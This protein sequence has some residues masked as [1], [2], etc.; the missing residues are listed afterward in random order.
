[1]PA[2]DPWLSRQNEALKLRGHG[3]AL[4]V[5]GRRVRLRATLPPKPTDPPGS[6]PKQHRISTGLAYPDQANEALQLAEKLGSALERHRVGMETF[7]WAPWLSLGRKK[8]VT[9]A[10]ASQG[11]AVSGTGAI[12]Q[13]HKWWLKQRPR[14]RSADESWKVDYQDPLA[15]LVGIEALNPEHLVSLVETTGAASR[16]RRRVSQATATVA[17]AL[18]WSD[19]L[20][21]QLRGMGKGYSAA[22]S[23]APRDLPRDEA[24]EALIDRLSTTW[25]WPVAVVAAYGCRPHEA[26]LFAEIQSSGLLRVSD[27]KTGARQSLA[28]PPKWVERWSLQ[29]KRLPRFNPERSHREVG[30]LMGQALRRAKADFQAYDL[31]HAWAVRAIHNP[32]ISPSLAAKSMGHSLAV[33]SNVYQRWFDAHEMEA[34]QSKLSSVA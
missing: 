24:I 22:K 28:L 27:G 21:S 14:G 15:L 3:V 10:Q 12:R 34:V 6:E 23:Q 7:D 5:A 25:Q 11:I 20:V 18:G 9:A 32:Q 29:N 17:R 4:D 30:A 13:A 31:R 19:D 26:L 1:M 16:T 2:S 8:G 33:H